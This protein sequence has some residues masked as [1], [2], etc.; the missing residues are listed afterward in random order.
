MVLIGNFAAETMAISEN[1]A[2]STDKHFLAPNT[3]MFES[4]DASRLKTLIN[5]LQSIFL[6]PKLR[7]YYL[8]SVEHYAT[9]AAVGH[10]TVAATR[11][12]ERPSDNDA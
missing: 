10:K 11:A 4:I 3:L 7:V 1:F 8:I 2:A 5:Y 9:Y 12:P 6:A